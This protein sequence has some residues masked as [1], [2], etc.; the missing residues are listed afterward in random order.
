MITSTDIMTGI[1]MVLANAVPENRVYLQKCPEG[2]ERPS[3][4]IEY[5]KTVCRDVNRKT[6][7]KT[8]SFKLTCFA[9]EDESDQENSRLTEM[10]EKA[11]QAF[12][13]GYIPV[14]DRAV[15]VQNCTGSLDVDKAYIDLQFD[16]FD[17]RN[18]EVDNTPLITSVTTKIEEV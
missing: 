13:D 5:V 4:L 2:F 6:V 11:I 12:A 9:P 17:D 3:F 8:I 1:A 18:D 10:Q 15:K 14:I 7:G 16:F